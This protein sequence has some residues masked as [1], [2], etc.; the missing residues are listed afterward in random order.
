MAQTLDEVAKAKRDEAF[1][2]N[3]SKFGYDETV[4]YSYNHP[5][6]QAD[7]DTKGRGNST[8]AGGAVGGYAAPYDAKVGTSIDIEKR[9][10]AI[11]YN[12]TLTGMAPETPYIGPELT[13]YPYQS[14]P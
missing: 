1:A 4:A 8:Y 3:H 13:E 6:A 2:L 14:N 7:G 9:D 10:E 12:G 11:S 5:N